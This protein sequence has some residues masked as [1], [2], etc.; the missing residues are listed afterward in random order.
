MDEKL[1]QLALAIDYADDEKNVTRLKSL[2]EECSNSAGDFDGASYAYCL[3][4][5]AN[6]HAALI[7]SKPQ[8]EDD[9]WSWEQEEKVAELLCLRKAA[10][11]SGFVDLDEVSQCKIL[12]NT[13]G[14][15]SSL[16][17]PIEAVDA[18]DQAI[19]KIPKFAMAL[20]NRGVGLISY[21]RS[22]YDHGHAAVMMSHACQNLEA[23]LRKDA[24]WDSGPH[25][26]AQQYFARNKQQCAEHLGAIEFDGG[27]NLD[28]WA[29]GE[30]CTEIEY[31]EWCLRRKLFLSPLNDVCSLSVAAQDVIHLPSHVYPT[32]ESPRFVGYFNSLKQEYV[33]ARHLLFKG[34][35]CD[36][37][38]YAD[39]DVLLL[40]ANDGAKFGYW[41]ENLKI[42]YRLLYSLL[43]K[44]ALFLNEYFSVG[45]APGAVNFRRIWGKVEKGGVFT[46]NTVF[47]DKKNW[48]LRGLFYVS[49]D[50]FDEELKDTSLPQSRDL[51]SIRNRAE[52][53]FVS[54]VYGTPANIETD[55][56]H[57]HEGSTELIPPVP[58]IPVN[59]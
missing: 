55:K 33:T 4:L 7:R 2:A 5:Q 39:R 30:T 40:H 21:G 51:S 35:V 29:L 20:G 36:D 38:H 52:H 43:D 32:G 56:Q 37:A 49:K 17:R 23:A 6:C 24:F 48:P 18:W 58:S 26:E 16:G 57:R 8:K 54:L 50:L 53:R 27:T 12:T 31:R 11:A 15:L 47:K 59:R 22:L 44:V 41:H 45:L 3:F 34:A 46:L 10:T 42:A 28:R 1:Y 19:L 9:E 13:A 14:A 25:P